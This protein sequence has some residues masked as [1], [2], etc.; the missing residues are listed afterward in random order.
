MRQ[1]G[2]GATF[3][4]AL[5]ALLAL[6]RCA[7]CGQVGIVLCDP[8]RTALEGVP[9]RVPVPA[10]PGAPPAAACAPYQGSVATCLNAWKERGRHDLEPIL[11]AVLGRSVAAVAGRTDA[12]RGAGRPGTSLL[13][14]PVPSSRAARRRRGADGVRR[15]AQHAARRLRAGG[16]PVRVLP[17]LRLTRRVA[18]QAGLTAGQRA[19]NLGG[20]FAVRAGAARLLAGRRVVVVD[21]VLTTGATLREAARAVAACDG[22]V[23]GL[24]CVSVTRRRRGLSALPGLD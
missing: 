14:V 16:V 2:A 23:V 15:L 5:L 8:C 3:A 9:T 19:T 6:P 10:W 1:I 13:L 24:A 17:A 7:G 18:D 4:G 22:R 20:A 21:D 12:H 11:G